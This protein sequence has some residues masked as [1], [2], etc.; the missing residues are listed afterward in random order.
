MNK[1]KSRSSWAN[2]LA[3]LGPRFM[4]FADAASDDLP[5]SRLLRLSLFQISV[6]M[7]M[8]MLVGTLNRV[9]IVELKVPAT[10][11]SFMV[12]LP[13]LMAPLR[14][15]IGF[16]SDNHR[17][18]LGWRRVPYIWMGSLLQFGGFSIMPFALL[19]LSGAGQSSQAPAWVGLV[20]AA[21]AFVLVGIGMHTVQT[22][23]LAL[24]TDLAPP[25][26]QPKVVG[27]MYVMQLL[28]MIGSALMLGHLLR[29]YSPGQLIRVVQAVAV[30]TLVLNVVALW[31][32]E[33]RSRTRK[34]GTPLEHSFG[35]AWQLFCQG[36]NTVR[37]LLA[38]G[39]GTMAFTMEDV[40]LE[41]YGGEILN[42]SVSTT[43]LLT[44]TL[45]LGGLIGFA[46]A[47]RV[48]SQGQDAYRMASWG[49]WVGVPAFV[50]VI[51]SAPMDSPVL[52][53]M[54][55]FL[56]G[57]G[58]GLFAHGT[59]TAT[60]QMAPPEQVGLAMGAWGAVQATAAGL[61]MAAGGLVRDGVALGS[62]SVLGYSAVYGLEIVLLALTLWAM[63]PMMRPAR[64][65]V[66]TT[67]NSA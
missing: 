5:L 50:C 32:Q 53:A 55:I 22:A 35:Q 43:T 27:L 15:L 7:A 47:S 66:R 54:G 19:V 13:L 6:G 48:L 57:L 37:R 2:S 18:Q 58:G 31:K 46:W 26:S 41:P 63:A 65:S 45:A 51:A 29:D 8:V 12:A 4:P 56:I 39:L 11:V 20:G 10:L 33:P 61:G 1:T 64:P 16:R 42:L 21:G 24:A 60:M 52:F 3:S 17:S 44:A 14:A 62:S 59:L 38:V 30:M 23:G 34:P 67:P 9:M 28:G 25:E 49:A 36:P 40:L